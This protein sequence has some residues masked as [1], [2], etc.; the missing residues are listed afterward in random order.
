MSIRE[1]ALKTV[2]CRV[3]RGKGMVTYRS[4]R[5]RASDRLRSAFSVSGRKK[6]RAWRASL[7]DYVVVWWWEF[8]AGRW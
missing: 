4:G 3:L 6:A 1:E 2:D 8:T 5:L 7:W